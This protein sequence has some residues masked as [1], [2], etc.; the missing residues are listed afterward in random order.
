M[1]KNKLILTFQKNQLFLILRKLE[2]DPAEFEWTEVES[3]AFSEGG[4]RSIVSILT[5]VPTSYYY[6]FDFDYNGYHYGLWSPGNDRANDAGRTENWTGQRS[7]FALWAQYLKREIDEPDLWEELSKEI[8]LAEVAAS[9]TSNAPFSIE[10]QQIV[11]AKLQEVKEYIRSTQ[12]LSEEKEEFI[13]K[14][15]TYLEESAKRQGR[16]DWLHTA[17]GVFFTIVIGAAYAPDAAR[18]LFRFIGTTFQ[19]ILNTMISL[20]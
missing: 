15:L 11:V 8:K 12:E 14:R 20:P 2:L 19:Q 18:E 3:S 1:E 9:D 17:I 4:S 16:S 13:N 7:S 10:E 5:H 6:K